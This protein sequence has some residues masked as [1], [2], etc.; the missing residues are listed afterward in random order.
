MILKIASFPSKP[1]I[2]WE[3]FVPVANDH[4]RNDFKQ[5]CSTQREAVHYVPLRDIRGFQENGLEEDDS[6]E[7]KRNEN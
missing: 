1:S 3:Y 4:F 5:R 7:R 2:E 6:L